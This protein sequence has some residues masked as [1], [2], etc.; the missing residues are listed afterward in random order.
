MNNKTKAALKWLASTAIV[1]GIMTQPAVAGERY[2]YKKYHYS[3][4][5]QH[6]PYC[7]HDNRQFSNYNHNYQRPKRHYFK[8]DY[9]SN[10][11]NAGFNSRTRHYYKHGHRNWRGNRSGFR[12]RE[13]GSSYI[14]IRF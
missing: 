12:Y 13:R 6:D 11:R 14:K 9:H 4:A 5:H 3:S 7:R 1:I 10:N 2:H 8:H